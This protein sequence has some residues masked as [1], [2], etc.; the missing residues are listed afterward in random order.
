VRERLITLACATGALVLFIILFLQPVGALDWRESVPRPTSAE[1]RDNGYYAAAAW[2]RAAGVRT[3][4]LRARS[5]GL[6][7]RRDLP[8]AGNVLVITLPGT[9]S[10]R[11]A[12]ARAVQ[13]WVRA[14]NTLLI[15]AALEDN[16]DW[17]NVAGGVSVGDL[18]VLS[19][20]DFDVATV[21]AA[22]VPATPRLVPN[23]PHAYFSGVASA[24]SSAPR[25]SQ[26]WR[27][28]IPYDSYLLTLAHEASSTQPLIWTR[29][30]GEGRIVVCALGSLFTDAALGRADNA[31]LLSNVIAAS[32]G[33]N[34]VVIFDDYHQ[35]LSTAYDPDK[36]YADPRLHRTVFVL[37]GLWLVWVL[38][39]TRLRTPVAHLAAPREVDLVKAHGAFLARALPRTIAAR[40]LLE[41]LFRRL[42]LR[43]A[44]PQ[45]D[46]WQQLRVTAHVSDADLAQ[47]QRW[48]ARALAGEPV[49]LVRLY[50]LI[51]RI[52]GQ[53]S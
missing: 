31:R 15:L 34:G 20:I 28:H 53:V 23:R 45:T 3:G 46:P 7:A 27:A 10:Y 33:R 32:L 37:L 25:S 48:R 6:G 39:A 12:E 11:L 22:D 16:P 9:D 47:L 50:N 14:G 43:A 13:H 18:K 4:S 42:A 26:E 40:R 30:L 38:G 44:P 1:S 19:G 5:D 41:H 36:F 24:V 2:L 17:S 51:C 52:G 29:L 21:P 35:G 49:P 8:I